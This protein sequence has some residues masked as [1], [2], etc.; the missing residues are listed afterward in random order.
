MKD[1]RDRLYDEFRS[2]CNH[3]SCEF[4][5]DSKKCGALLDE[6]LTENDFIIESETVMRDNPD[7]F[8]KPTG[9]KPNES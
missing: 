1:K 9:G 7:T 5:P 6:M 4:C 2:L 3:D 8:A